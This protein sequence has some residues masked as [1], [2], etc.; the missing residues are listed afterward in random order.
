MTEYRILEWSPRDSP[1]GLNMWRILIIE[2]Y[3]NSVDVLVTESFVLMA[4]LKTLFIVRVGQ[5]YSLAE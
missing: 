3:K 4:I 1:E 5:T 2:R